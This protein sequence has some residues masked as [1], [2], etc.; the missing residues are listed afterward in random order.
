MKEYKY[1]I[2]QIKGM[3]KQMVVLVDSREQKNGHILDYFQRQGIPYKVEKLDFGDYSCKLPAAAAGRDIYFHDSV[4]IERKNSL[5]EISGNLTKGRERFETEFLKARN[6]GAKIYLMIEDARGFTG[7][8]MHG[9][10]TQLKP[11][12]FMASLKTW[13][14]R[15]DANIQF[16]DSQFSGYYIATTLQYFVRE[17]LR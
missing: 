4:V 3:L 13:E 2:E 10:K 6:A 9:Y 14:H 5:E 8:V 1:S 15:F 16:V 11:A 12:A 17:A 7:I